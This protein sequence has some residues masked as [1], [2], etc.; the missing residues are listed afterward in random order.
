M[1]IFQLLTCNFLPYGYYHV[2]VLRRFILH[3]SS[4]DHYS[5]LSLQE[6][7]VLIQSQND[8]L[9]HSDLTI[10]FPN[11]LR[12]HFHLPII[13]RHM[14]PADCPLPFS[15]A[16]DTLPHW[17]SLSLIIHYLKESHYFMDTRLSLTLTPWHHL[18]NHKFE[19][20]FE[21]LDYVLPGLYHHFHRRLDCSLQ[22]HLK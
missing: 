14:N 13:N 4:L 18:P 15:I 3:P 12:A 8:F 5:Q 7:Q 16:E 20:N 11:H 9:C 1:T 22:L 6:F 19:L 10:H 21:V 17:Y 2:D